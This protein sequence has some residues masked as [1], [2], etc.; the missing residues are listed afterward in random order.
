MKDNGNDINKLLNGNT[1]SD[2]NLSLDIKT[3]KKRGRK[4]KKI[5]IENLDEPEEVKPKK[6]RGRKPKVQM[7]TET[8]KTPKK[9]GRKPIMSQIVN[10]PI[11]DN[12]LIKDNVL[13]LKINN[14]DIENNI[15]LETLYK[16]NPDINNPEPYDPNDLYNPTN[17]YFKKN[18]DENNDKFD[19]N[20]YNLN[21]ID[22]IELDEIRKKFIE[23]NISDVIK[24]EQ[25]I[26]ETLNTE[27]DKIKKTESVKNVKNMKNNRITLEYYNEYNKRKEW[28]K[29]S[30]I[31][32]FWCCHNFT[33]TPAALPVKMKGDVFHVFGNFCSKECAAAY[34]FS[35]GEND[36]IVYERYTLLN[37]MYSLIE[38][39]HDLKIK[40]SP[41]RMTLKMF[42]GDLTIEQF[43]ESNNLSSKYKI[44]YPPMVSVIPS[45][46]VNNK[47][48]LGKKNESFYIPIDKDR[49]KK[50]NND[51][52][53]KRRKPISNRNTLE[54]CMRLK[55]N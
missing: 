26:N 19:V 37:Y 36:Q 42:G 48:D 12:V 2:G 24:Q 52:R 55:Y 11:N 20:N 6:K 33:C 18:E 41:P 5:Q 1:N 32:C 38:N 25:D 40:L 51:L 39:N 4:P 21:K 50:V 22:N 16:Y 8:V 7:E 15:L 17:L 43:R 9:R 45:I 53:L 30:N 27:N 13:H 49:I 23:S 46:E 54:N 29:K 44:V 14:T 34:N 10:K 47:N 3:P 31:N 35:S 28:P